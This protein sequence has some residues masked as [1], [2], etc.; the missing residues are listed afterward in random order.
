MKTTTTRTISL[1]RKS[2]SKSLRGG[3]IS[4]INFGIRVYS[5][6]AYSTVGQAAPKNVTRTN[7]LF[8]VSMLKKASILGFVVFEAISKPE[9][10]E[11]H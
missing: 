2:L 1:Y 4:Q 7:F 10:V 6:G 8:F 11:K 9:H 3:L 5:R